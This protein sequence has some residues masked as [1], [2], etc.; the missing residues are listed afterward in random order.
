[1]MRFPAKNLRYRG[2]TLMDQN[3]MKLKLLNNRII[4]YRT[5]QNDYR[6]EVIFFGFSSESWEVFNVFSCPSLIAGISLTRISF[7][8]LIKIF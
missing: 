7:K 3:R 2:S 5:A 1:M 4:S 8:T 6:L